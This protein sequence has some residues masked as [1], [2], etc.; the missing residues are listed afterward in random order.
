V[1]AALLSRVGEP[2]AAGDAPEPEAGEGTV[3]L[4]VLAAPL[5]PI[6][7]AVGEGRF[8]AGRP[9]TPYV[10]GKEGVGRV[11]EGER[12]GAT[13]YFQRPG[14]LGGREGA[15]AERAAAPV[16][17]LWDVPEGLDPV[18][19]SCFGVAGLAAWLPLEWRAEL[20]EGETV[21]VLGAS[22]ALG[23]I[24]VQAAKLLGAGRVVAAARSEEGL[25]RARELGADATVGLADEKDLPAAL[26]EAAEGEIDV[27][28]DPLWGEP[29]VAALAATAKGGRL[30]QIGQS[31]GPEATIPSAS[32]R[33]KLVSI[34]GHTSGAAPPG[35]QAAAYAA[36][37][38]HAAAGRLTVDRETFGL[39]GV[40]ASWR[41]QAAFP[42]RKLVGTP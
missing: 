39:D 24:A 33:G 41:A 16:G 40:G 8:Y 29:A 14:G 5:N 22:G 3:L 2:P 42:R 7:L 31:A 30:V 37:V 28:V 38:E 32:V 23:A 19:A 9:E 18:L 20:R 26:R 4:D 1:R 35:V 27:T 15:L 11:L 12:A 10:V 17:S 13:V 25:V 6:D 34:L 36:M 21:L